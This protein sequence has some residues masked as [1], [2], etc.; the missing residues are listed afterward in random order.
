MVG[1][2]DKEAMAELEEFKAEAAVEEKHVRS[3]DFG[4]PWLSILHHDNISPPYL[5]QIKRTTILNTL[6][7]KFNYQSYLE[8]GQGRREHNFD[9]VNCPIKIGVDPNVKLDAA[10]QM[11]SDDFFAQN[12]DSFDIIFIDGLHHADQVERDIVNSLEVL[13][14]NGTIV[15]HDCNP[16]TQAMQIVPRQHRSWTGDV[17][18]AWVKLRATRPDLKMYVINTESGCGIIRRG[19]QETISIP[20]ELTYS[21][22]D[23]NRKKFLNLVDMNYFLRD[24]KNP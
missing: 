5:N 23:K 13:N 17:W 2:Q 18:K 8:I 24:L 6:I 7:E 16:T 4:K 3:D 9:W 11:T 20:G 19:K 1:C 12:K 10:Y 15:V 14:E 21:M 22:L